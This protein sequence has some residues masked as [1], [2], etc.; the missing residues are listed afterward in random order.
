M[1]TA[2]A[3]IRGNFISLNTYTNKADIHFSLITASPKNM[4]APS[5]TTVAPL[6]GLGLVLI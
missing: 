5:T 6:P 2:K 4:L 1:D 3:F